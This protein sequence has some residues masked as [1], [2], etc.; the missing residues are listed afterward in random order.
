MISAE[1]LTGSVLHQ[2]S[3][4]ISNVPAS[5]QSNFTSGTMYEES[6]NESGRSQGRFNEFVSRTRHLELLS[7]LNDLKQRISVLENIV[8]AQEMKQRNSVKEL[9]RMTEMQCSQIVS[10]VSRT[11]SHISEE[12]KVYTKQ[13]KEDSQKLDKVTQMITSISTTRTENQTEND[14]ELRLDE[15]LASRNNELHASLQP[16]LLELDNIFEELMDND[17]S[18]Q[19]LKQDKPQQQ[20]FDSYMSPAID[21]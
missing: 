12:M 5:Q 17:E 8:N 18:L 16:P 20:E 1:N 14:T 13:L 9:G 3:V 6:T 21:M 10:A 19:V 4:V 15:Y 2:P 7:V 11:E